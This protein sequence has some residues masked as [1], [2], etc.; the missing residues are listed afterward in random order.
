MTKPQRQAIV[1]VALCTIGA[2]LVNRA[3]VRLRPA[4][5][6]WPCML[7]FPRGPFRPKF[8]FPRVGGVAD[9]SI[10]SQNLRRF[11]IFGYTSCPL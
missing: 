4:T 6:S 8:F 10:L 11:G 3:T 7:L 9:H 2:F 1:V 5:R